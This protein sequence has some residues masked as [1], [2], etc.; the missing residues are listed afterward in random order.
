MTLAFD[1][2]AIR[3]EKNQTKLSNLFQPNPD[4]KPRLLKIKKVPAKQIRGYVATYHY[5]HI[6]PDNSME[7]YAGYYKE[8]LAGVV[9]FGNG[10]SNEAFTKI[11]PTIKVDEARELMRLWC[12]DEMPKNTETRIIS[13]AIKSLPKKVKLVISFA[14][15][16][17]NH[18]G[19]IYQASN[20]VYLG[21]TKPNKMLLNKEGNKFH[22]R[23]I[24]SYKRRH[25]EIR[26]MSHEEIMKKYDWKYATGNAKHKYFKL[27]NLSHKEKKKIMKIIK[28]QI[29]PYPKKNLCEGSI[30]N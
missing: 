17:I 28:E 26:G 14:D 20:F 1:K 18:K 9:V 12:P 23:T 22:I 29:K 30:K 21:M 5:T 15:D 27:I 8:K 4:T 13:E 11:I 24:G 25:P 6:M 10:A 7:C 3:G 16:G 2:K 19:T